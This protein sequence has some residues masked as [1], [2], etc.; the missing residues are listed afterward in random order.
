MHFDSLVLCAIRRELSTALIGGRIDKIFQPSDTSLAL[1]VR[2]GGHNHQLLLST[3]PQW[4]RIHLVTVWKVTSG[5]ETPSAFVMLLRKHCEGARIEGLEQPSHERVLRIDLRQFHG[6]VSRTSALIIEAMGRRSNILLV[7]PDGVILGIL[8]RVT[9]AMSQQR[10]LRVHGSYGPPPQPLMTLAGRED[11]PKRAPESVSGDDLSRLASGSASDH[12]VA[13]LLVATIA[14]VS[15]TLAKELAYRTTGSVSTAASRLT[16]RHVAEEVARLLRELFDRC[17]L[18][19]GE[20]SLAVADARPVAFAPYRLCQLEATARVQPLGSM[21]FA[22]DRFFAAR[23]Q[24]GSVVALR[25][26]LLGPVRESKKRLS[27]LQAAL[28]REL[29]EARAEAPLRARGE[30]LLA[31][32]PET[33]GRRTVTVPGE[34][35]E[36]VEIP[37]DPFLTATENAQ[38]L[39]KRYRKARAALSMLPDR[40]EATRADLAY[41]NQMETDVALA[42]TRDE[43]R[44]LGA[45]LTKGTASRERARAAAPATKRKGGRAGESRTSAPSAASDSVAPRSAQVSGY[46]VL[47]GR[48]SRQ[49]DELT[50]RTARRQDMWLH[51]RQAPGSHVIV[52]RDT[53]SPVPD[54]VLAAA[55]ATAAYYSANRDAA[56]VPVDVTEVSNVRRMPGGK[57]GMVVYTGERTLSVSPAPVE[58]L[59][60]E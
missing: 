28:Q 60:P 11:D 43:L 9:P 57:P 6:G 21:S 14:G 36:P 49:N 5:F 13:Q 8:R 55:A 56:T 30:L 54:T 40:L 34:D 7:D 58:S 23:E 39:F 29:D 10:P 42:E 27:A 35:G 50:F 31:Y 38:R 18:D 44:A 47:I 53:P 22:V 25:Q 2:S 26:R 46:P 3:H 51:A 45:E 33:K 48:N 59:A 16:E 15:P 37:V 52:R 41:A 24:S 19:T 1:H 32:Q 4:A 17:S 20:P 12:A